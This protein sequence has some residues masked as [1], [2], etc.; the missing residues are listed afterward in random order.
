MRGPERLGGL[1]V[2]LALAAAPAWGALG[3]AAAS[4]Q[5]DQIRLGGLRQRAMGPSV[6]TDTLTFADGSTIRQYVGA[7]GK[8][9]AIEWHTQFKPRL[10]QLLGRYFP[11]YVQAGRQAMAQRPGPLR[12]V[13]L[14]QGDLVV[15]ASQHLN[16]HAG[17]AWLVSLWPTGL[18]PDALR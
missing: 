7:D 17:R 16:A 15:Q 10:D 3:E 11:A 6:Q 2:A 13:E 8:V 18:S 9:F 5:A 14:H 12:R 1:L 4:V